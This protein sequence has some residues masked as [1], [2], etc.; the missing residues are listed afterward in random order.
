M[1]T[2]QQQKFVKNILKFTAPAL[3]V[4][5]LQLSQG[6]DIK[7]AGMVALLALYG[8]LADYLSKVNG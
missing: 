8:L 6:V 3:A 1:R 4:F 7:T 2:E 5:F